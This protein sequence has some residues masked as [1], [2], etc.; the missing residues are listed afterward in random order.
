MLDTPA[1]VTELPDVGKN[2]HTSGARSEVFPVSSIG[3]SGKKDIIGENEAFL[4]T[5]REKSVFP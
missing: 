2:L 3:D 4:Y 5:G 1:G